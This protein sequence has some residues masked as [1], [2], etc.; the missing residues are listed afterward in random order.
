MSVESSVMSFL[1]D[2]RGSAE[3]HPLPMVSRAIHA[4]VLGI[5]GG[6]HPELAQRLHE[7][8]GVPSFSVG[9]LPD[10]NRPTGLLLRIASLDDELSRVFHDLEPQ[11]VPALELAGISLK[12]TNIICPEDDDQRTGS[13]SYHELYNDGIARA[14]GGQTEIGLR[15]ITPTSFRLAGSRL[16]MPLPWPKL[17]FQ[18]LVNKWNRFSPITIEVNWE[19]LDRHVSIARHRLKTR[20]IDF[21]CYKQVGFMGECYYIIARQ[22]GGHLLQTLH[23]LG[24]FAVYS[25]VGAKTTMGMGQVRRIE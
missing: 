23:T 19:D 1:L 7:E 11:S 14:R 13:T 12:L 21:G 15:F 10:T 20:M 24:E 8:N 16:N 3:V 2:F 25:G 22:A 5:I 17:V 6:H 9:C 18:S 4:Y